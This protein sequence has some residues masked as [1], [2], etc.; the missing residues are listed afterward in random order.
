VRQY[1]LVNRTE[2]PFSVCRIKME[3]LEESPSTFGEE[4]SI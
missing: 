2:R 4:K 3:S 1:T